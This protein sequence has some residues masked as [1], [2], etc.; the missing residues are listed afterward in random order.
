MLHEVRDEAGARASSAGRL[1]STANKP[2]NAGPGV[3]P[4]QVRNAPHRVSGT[5][6]SHKEE[7]N[8]FRHYGIGSGTAG[9]LSGQPVSRRGMAPYTP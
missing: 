8:L 1:A 6:M 2:G 9:P 5:G 4:E 3:R 7:A